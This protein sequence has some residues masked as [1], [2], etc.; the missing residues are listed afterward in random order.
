M[1]LAGR[2]LLSSVTVTSEFFTGSL[3]DW[4]FLT[5]VTLNQR[6]LGIVVGLW[7]KFSHRTSL[8]EMRRVGAA[9]WII[10]R[11]SSKNV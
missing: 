1:H 8:A 2:E 10:L 9:M 11:S 6:P 7:A 4:T 5:R 3:L